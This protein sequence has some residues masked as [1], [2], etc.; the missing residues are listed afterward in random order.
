M[1]DYPECEKMQAVKEESQKLGFFLETLQNK[2]TLCEWRDGYKD[3][4]GE[5]GSDDYLWVPEGYY[6]I[7]RSIQSI[8]ADYFE[9]DLQKVA[10][11]QAQILKEI[12][13]KG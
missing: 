12:R 6:P 5:E 4:F 3:Y 9:I 13:E 2:Y 1:T 8:L 11:E 7:H 10:E